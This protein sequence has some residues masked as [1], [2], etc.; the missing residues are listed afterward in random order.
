MLPPAV[1]AQ[2]WESL[3]GSL[4]HL[5][6]V[7]VLFDVIGLRHFI[8]GVENSLLIEAEVEVCI[9]S[10]LGQEFCGFGP[11]QIAP[12]GGLKPL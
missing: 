2:G 1:H 12:G 7:L 6:G 4:Q 3:T 5:M 10:S 11:M 9:N 8:S